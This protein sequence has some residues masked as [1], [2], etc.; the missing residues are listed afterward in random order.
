MSLLQFAINLLAGFVEKEIVVGERR[1]YLFEY[2][3][4][5]DNGDLMS[6]KT[7]GRHFVPMSS[8]LE[9]FLSDDFDCNYRVGTMIP[10]S[11]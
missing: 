11:S 1:G 5:L 8:I 10:S 9:D 4:T 3:L 7:N 6:I 2:D